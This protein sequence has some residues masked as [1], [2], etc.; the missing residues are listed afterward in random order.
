MNSIKKYISYLALGVVL[1]SCS[2]SLDLLP[3]DRII[4]E[5]AFKDVPSLDNGL[6][7]VYATFNGAYDNEIYASA[8][9]SDEATLPTENNTGRGVLTYRWQIDP[10]SADVTDSWAAYYF[11]IDRANRILA[12]AEGVPTKNDEEVADKERIRGEA[13]ALRAF[14]HLQLLINFSNGFDPNALSVPYMERSEISKPSRLK[15]SEVLAKI[16]AD[17]DAAEDLVPASNSATRITPAVIN[18]IRA[19]AA[20]YGKNWDVAI[21]A[22]TAAINEVGLDSRGE[23]IEIW[24]DDSNA[25]VIWKH[26]RE[27]GEFRIGDLFWD[28]TQQKIMYGPSK[29]LRDAFDQDNDIR[30]LTTVYQPG[31]GRYALNKYIG[32]D[33]ANENLADVKVFRTAEMYL[34]RAEAYAEKGQLNEAAADLNALRAARIEGYTDE[35]F[36]SKDALIAAI[37]AERFKELAFEGQRISDLRRRGLSVTRLAEDAINALGAVT[38]NPA[39]KEYYYPIPSTEILAN[40]NMEQNP[41]YQ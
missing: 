33:P 26:R 25:G 27:T 2:K 1:A 15:V 36:S 9:Y 3:T 10:G 4:D 35:T 20:L 7:G 28:R 19:R 31:S 29:E 14:G 23:H 11:G 32:G 13:L 6:T 24:T 30:Y 41:S 18:A 17:L 34:I 21:A 16:N 40:E 8:L 22:A 5:N 39:D 38:L 37:I 12:A